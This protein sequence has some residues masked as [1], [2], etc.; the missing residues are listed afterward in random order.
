MNLQYLKLILNGSWKYKDEES[1]PNNKKNRILMRIERW[2]VIGAVWIK[3][4]REKNNELTI[5]E[6]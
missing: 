2:F 4:M 3:S 1:H 6:W 5:M